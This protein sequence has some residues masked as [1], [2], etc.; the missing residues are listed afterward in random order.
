MGRDAA[1]SQNIRFGAVRSDRRGADA[2]RRCEIIG[3]FPAWPPGH[4]LQVVG[5]E[6]S[7]WWFT[8]GSP[9]YRTTNYLDPATRQI[10]RPEAAIATASSAPAQVAWKIS[11]RLAGW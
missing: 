4:W 8:A 1:N 11:S 7:G 6:D 3:S 5:A 9:V 10:A 2:S